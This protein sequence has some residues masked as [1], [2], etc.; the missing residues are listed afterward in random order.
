MLCINIVNNF[1]CFQ[2]K[3][4]YVVVCFVSCIIIIILNM[5]IHFFIS[6]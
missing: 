5:S 3:Y 1:L 2:F 6:V 4:S